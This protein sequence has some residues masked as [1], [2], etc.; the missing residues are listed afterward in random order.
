ME[1]MIVKDN[2]RVLTV[3]G[4]TNFRD[5]G[6]Y[7]TQDGRSVKWGLLF[8][9][10]HLNNISA[11]GL[12]TVANLNLF[13]II[14]LRSTYEKDRQPDKLPAGP[15]LIHLPV[16]DEA[17]RELYLEIHNRIKNRD[18]DG[19]NAEEH[20][21][22]AYHQFATDF[23]PEFKSYIHTVVNSNGSPVLWHC[24]A[25]KDRTGYAAAILLQLLGVDLEI[26]YQDYLLSNQYARRINKTVLTAI[27]ARG[28]KAYRMIKPLLQVERKWLDKALLSINNKWG[29]FQSYVRDGLELDQKDIQ[30]LQ[31][32]LLE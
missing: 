21:F 15:K 17:N 13:S 24:T 28:M 30:K 22:N 1:Q 6:G 32:T 5:M 19:F 20:I 7:P 31:D 10:A 16:M 12:K 14:D 11:H 8:R 18:F 29:D 4:V 27:L 26:I 9:S 3:R 2:S 25:G 23:T